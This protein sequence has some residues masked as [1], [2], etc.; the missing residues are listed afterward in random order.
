MAVANTYT[1]ENSYGSRVVVSGAGF[2]LN[3]EMIDF[4]PLPGVT[5]RDG[6]IGTE[7]NLIAPGKRMLSLA[8]ADHRGRRTASRCWSPAAPAGGRSSTPCCAS[9]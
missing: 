5:D 1:L 8:D 2:L 4:N 3:N 7:P 9:W 6:P